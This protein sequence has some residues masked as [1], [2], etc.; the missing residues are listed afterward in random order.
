MYKYCDR[1]GITN[2]VIPINIMEISRVRLGEMSLF[3]PNCM[4]SETLSFISTNIEGFYRSYKNPV[5]Y[6]ANILE[7][8]ERENLLRAWER[9]RN[10][11]YSYIDEKRTEMRIALIQD[12]EKIVEYT[13]RE[14]NN[15]KRK[16]KRQNARLQ[17]RLK[18]AIKN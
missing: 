18:H 12:I 2:V 17:Q 8:C 9:N 3:C 1:C 13:K 11:V 4:L 15:R 14:I 10:K 7:F 6:M 16:E 5:F